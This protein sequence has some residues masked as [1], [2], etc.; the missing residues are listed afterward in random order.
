M[1][2]VEKRKHNPT[3]IGEVYELLCV[4]D[5]PKVINHFVKKGFCNPPSK[6]RCKCTTIY[7]YLC[8]EF[9]LNL[10]YLFM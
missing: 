10:I 8:S 9:L 2:I 3:L 1:Y 4:S 5:D 7:D 6:V